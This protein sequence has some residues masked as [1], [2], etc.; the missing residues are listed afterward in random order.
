MLCREFERKMIIGA[1]TVLT[2]EEAEAAI[3]SGAKYI[4]SPHVSPEIIHTT[5]KRGAVS[6]PGAFT[7]TEI[8]SAYQAGALR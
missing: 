6:I 7:P 2:S 4:L 3:E 8:V 5:L 1:G